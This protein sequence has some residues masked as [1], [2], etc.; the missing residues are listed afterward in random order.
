M[1]PS[2]HHKEYDNHAVHEPRGYFYIESTIKGGPKGGP[3]VK[4]ADRVIIG[5]D[6]IRFFVIYFYSN[7]VV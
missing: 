4:K 1:N 2:C 3:F 6:F 7:F 5:Y